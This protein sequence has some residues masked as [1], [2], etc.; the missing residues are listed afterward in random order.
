MAGDERLG[1]VRPDPRPSSDH[2]GHDRWLV[3]RSATDPADLTTAETDRARALLAACTE[4]AAL[5]ADLGDISHATATSVVPPRPRDF[6]LT[7]EQAA[8]ARGGVL[9]RLRRWLGTPGAFAVRPLAGA[10]LAIGLL[11]VVVTPAL[12]PTVSTQ[13][14]VRTGGDAQTMM[15]PDGTAGATQ[16]AK[17]TPVT[18][19]AGPEMYAGTQPS[20]DPALRA[21]IMMATSPTPTDDPDTTAAR[22][23]ET[24]SPQEG[25][26]IVQEDGGPAGPAADAQPPTDDVA[27]VL[28]LLGIVLA[29]TG[30]MVLVLSWF[31]R[32]WQDPLLR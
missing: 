7:S 3:V 1:N 30:L 13:D 16:V 8:A 25:Q 14:E 5:A 2:A 6:R 32:R 4:C 28:T 29:T 11:L 17:A 10:T 12:R 22:M 21:D 24:P 20:G 27:Y 23:V 31:A 26:G 18:D 19:P 15:A 9:D